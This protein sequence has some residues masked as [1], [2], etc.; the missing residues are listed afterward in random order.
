V[1][2]EQDFSL[3]ACSPLQEASIRTC[4]DD[5]VSCNEHD[6]QE[7]LMMCEIAGVPQEFGESFC[8]RGQECSQLQHG[9]LSQCIS[10]C[11]RSSK[12]T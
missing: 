11:T 9:V 12:A 6:I 8:V 10:N 7:V 1:A 2:F 5:C 4:Q 3:G